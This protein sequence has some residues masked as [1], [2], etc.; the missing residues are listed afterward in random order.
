[1]KAAITVQL[2]GIVSSNELYEWAC[3]S[4][5]SANK[6]RDVPWKELKVV[7]LFLYESID[8]FKE[9]YTVKLSGLGTGVISLLPQCRGCLCVCWCA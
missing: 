4:V 5:L 1:M 6:S 2:I 7:H 9:D 8:T 3:I